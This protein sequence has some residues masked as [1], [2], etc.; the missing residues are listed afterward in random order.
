MS[1]FL[2]VVLAS[3]LAAFASPASAQQLLET[4]V[5][6]LSDRDHFNS[7]GERLWSAAAIIRQDRAN[8]HRFGIRDPLDQPDSFFSVMANRAKLE[9]MLERGRSDARAINAVI[10]GTPIIRVEIYG[11]G[12]VGQFINVIVE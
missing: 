7:K 10:H 1:K 11:S 3:I 9:S 2:M 8:F 12:S 5:A 4:Y 6:H